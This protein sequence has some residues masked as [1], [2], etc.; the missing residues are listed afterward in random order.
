MNKKRKINSLPAQIDLPAMEMGVLD[1]WTQNQVFEKSVENRNGAARWSFYEG[2][3]TAN[4]KPGTHHIEARVFKDLFPRFQTMKGKQV[5]RK[6][7]WDCHGLPVEIAV[8]KELGFTGKADIE[9]FGVAAF[10]EKCKESV[11]RHVDEF[12]DMTKRMG[13]WVDFDEAYWTMSPEYIESVW[14]SLQQIWNKGLLVQDHRVAPYCPRCGTGLSDHELAQGY[15]TI[16]D[17][18]VFVR[19]PVTS[20]K[21]AELKASLLVWTTTPWTLV[22]NT[23]V[24][25]NPKVEYQVVEITVDEKTERL[26]VAADLASVLGEDRKVIA[27]FIGKDLEHTKYSRPFDFVEINDSHFVV[28]ADYVTVEDG[29]GLVHQSPAFGADDLE[30]CRKYNLPVVNPVNPD[31]H[32]QKEVPLIGGVFF[33]DADK[34]LIKDLKSR[35]LMFKS[36][37]FEHSYPHC[38]RC[39]TALM[40]YAQPSW[41]VKTTAIKEDLLRENSKTNWHPETIKT[42]RFGDWLNNNIDWAVSRNRY[43]GTP[44]PIWRC[45]NK[46]EICVG[47]LAEL[48]KLAG[49]ELSKL[50]PHRPFVD[51]IK[52]KCDKCSETMQRIPEVI[53]CWYDSGAMPFA[54]WGYPHQSGSVEKFNATYPADF[55]CEAIDQTRGWFYTLMT[56]GTLVFDK[57]SYK[58]VLCLGHILDKDGRK[59]SKHLG[60]VLEPM[61]LMNQHGADAVRWYMLAAGSPWSARRVGHDAISDVV[62]KTLLTYWNTISFFTLYANAADFEVS[63]VSA[64]L[65]LMDKWIL[66]ELNKLIVGVDKALENFDSQEAGQLLAAF[67]DD[68]SNWYVRRSRRRFWDGDEVALN[69]LYFCLK[70]LTLLLAPMVPFIAE[71]VWQSLI[72]VAEA[73]QVESVHLADFPEANKKMIDENLSTSVALSRRLVELGRSARAESGVKIRQPL[74]RALVSAPGWAKISEEIKTHIAEELNILKLDGIHVAEA[75]LVDVSVKANFRTLGTKFGADVQ[76]IAKAITS[77][78]HTEMVKHLRENKSFK[79]SVDL[80]NGSKSAEIDIDDLVVTETP[81]TGWSVASHAG[82]SLALDLALTPELIQS[83]LVREVIRAIQEERKKIGLDVSDRISVNWNAPDQVASAITSAVA[84]ISAEVL[85][86]NLVQDKGQSSD[87]NELGLWLNLVKN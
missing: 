23:A 50:D 60:N 77:A 73:D 82:E 56:I 24:A 14:W 18:S 1:F 65:T 76:I 31:G 42:G 27:T 33:K 29:T 38:W 4:G 30:V 8:E 19:F 28:L 71:H 2:P 74:S 75:D 59:M 70:N 46:H 79:L 48:G 12:T 34:A 39:H 20:G 78:N 5:I 32:F 62:R 22:S 54:Q 66:S 86:T 85:A 69:T 68:L 35:G 87:G 44:L 7:G 83:G 80:T 64:D 21:L 49:Q 11:Q 9:K 36:L 63:K 10:N 57:S 25:V 52:F 41:Y 84:E 67:I 81:R 3:P 43:W 45:E 51:D 47:S 55:I 15:E 58:T 53:D 16:K 17:P 72:K 6:A 37:Q 40:Y 13:F 61:P 26:V